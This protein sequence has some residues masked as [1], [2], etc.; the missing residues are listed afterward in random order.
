[1]LYCQFMALLIR[2]LAAY[3]LCNQLSGQ[4]GL[5]LIT[6]IANE[7]KGT[8]GHESALWG[9]EFLY[10]SWLRHK[11]DHSTCWPSVRRV[12][13]VLRMPPYKKLKSEWCFR[14]Q[15]C[16]VR[17]YWAGDNLGYWDEFWYESCPRCRIDHLTCWP[18]VQR[19]HNMYQYKMFNT[20][21]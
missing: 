11:I 10:L 2:L 8:L 4:N 18:A 12:T 9:Y 3:C 21:L 16:T 5:Y 7:M 6:Y 20:Q 17:L 15:Y 1:M 14:L 19:R 13:I